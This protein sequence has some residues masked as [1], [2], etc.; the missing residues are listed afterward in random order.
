MYWHLQPDVFIAQKLLEYLDNSNR[1]SRGQPSEYLSRGWPNTPGF[2]A[3]LD[4]QQQPIPIWLYACNCLFDFGYVMV[5]Q[6]NNAFVECTAMLRW[7]S[8]K[9]YKIVNHLHFC[10]QKHH[11]GWWVLECFIPIGKKQ[12][13]KLRNGAI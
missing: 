9:T 11:I 3:W 1:T 8:R 4:L 7:S 13:H 10:K 5:V 2:Q 6:W 12:L